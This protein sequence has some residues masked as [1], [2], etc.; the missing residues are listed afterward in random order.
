[1]FDLLIVESPAKAQTIEKYL[2]KNY[3]VLSSKGHVRDLPKSSFGVDIEHNFEPKYITI[4]GKS[5]LINSLKKEAKAANTV[6]LATDPDREG[7][8]ISWHLYEILGL[9]EK[10]CKRIV[11]NEIT[12][13]ALQEAVKHPRDI[14]YDLVDAQQARRILDRIVGYKLSPFLW[15]KIRKGLSAGRVQSVATSMIVDRENEIRNFKPH[16]YWTLTAS[17]K[18]SNSKS[19]ISAKFHGTTK[20]AIEVENETQANEIYDNVIGKKFVV[21]ALKIGEKNK[22]PAPPFTTS[23]L[24]QDAS[25]KFNFQAKRTMK[26]AQELYEGVNIENIGLTGLITYIRTDSLRISDD[27]AETARS[28]IKENYGESFCPPTR[29]YYKTKKGA[30]DAHEAIRPTNVSLTP[31]IIKNSVT[32]DQYRLYKLIYERFIASQMSNAVYNT[33]SA[34]ITNGEYL[35]KAYCQSVKFKGYTVVY[36]DPEKEETDKKMFSLNENEELT[37]TELDKVQSFTQPPTRY[38]EGT[39]TKALDENGIG[40]PST[41]MPIISTILAR[42]YVERDGKFLKPTTLGEV[43]TKLMKDYFSSIIDYDF[44]ANLET[45]LDKVSDG[46][47]KWQDLISKFYDIF[48]N[49]LADAESALKETKISVPDEITDEICP[50]CGKNLVIKSGKF[51]KFLACP[52]YPDCK[53]TKAIVVDTGVPCPKCG[54]KIVQKRSK[55]GAIFYG[56]ENYPNCDYMSWDEPLTAKCEN[57]GSNLFRK[58][59]KRRIIYCPNPDCKKT[60]NKKSKDNA[61]G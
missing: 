52:G 44:S 12:K 47:I 11:F 31:E 57:C 25:R 3:K 22:S 21:K 51:G 28:Y 10:N 17:F 48:S 43:T 19:K 61:N 50:N 14:D 59:G 45:K 37:L 5:E 58:S 4:R 36:Q 33:Q 15:K 27:A 7:E 8:A 49:T 18:P 6:Y 55:K 54:G 2:G 30:Q 1:M 23:T 60:T 40:R 56:C 41:F 35:F 20:K 39:L 34:D 13:N 32:S 46:E 26:A 42:E 9:D 38:T 16:E 53:F 29:R 24:Q